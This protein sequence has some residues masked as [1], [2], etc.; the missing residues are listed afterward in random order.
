MNPQS[1]FPQS[2]KLF[3][4]FEVNLVEV[5]C[6]CNNDFRLNIENGLKSG[7]IVWTSHHDDEDN[8]HHNGNDIKKR[9]CPMK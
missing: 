9:Y 5:P 1:V 7:S 6:Y 4:Y 2:L 3:N 8:Q